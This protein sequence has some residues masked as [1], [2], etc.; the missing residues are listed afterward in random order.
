MKHTPGPRVG[1]E[2][3][4]NAHLIAAEPDLL[5]ALKALLRAVEL[6]DMDNCEI[7]SAHVAVEWHAASQGARAAIANANATGELT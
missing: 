6:R 4:A 2:V 5:K 3:H 7:R 1:G